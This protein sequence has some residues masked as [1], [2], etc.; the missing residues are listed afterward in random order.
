MTTPNDTVLTWANSNLQFEA[1]TKNL[2]DILIKAGKMSSMFGNR[3]KEAGSVYT[4]K[5]KVRWNP[6]IGYVEDG[7]AFP[8]AGEQTYV[9]AKVGMRYLAAKLPITDGVMFGID[10]SGATV[11]DEAT[12]ELQ[13][14]TESAAKLQNWMCF[15]DGTGKVATVK[16]GS[17]TTTLIV[18]DSRMMWEGG[19]YDIYDGSTYV[20]TVT[21]SS[22]SQTP[23]SNGW[24]TITL[25]AAPTNSMVSGYSVVW[26]GSYNRAPSGLRKLIDNTA[27]TF[28]NVN[29]STYSN[30]SSLVLAPYSSTN[31]G[32]LT[33]QIL[34]KALSG[35]KLKTGADEDV[36]TLMVSSTP[37]LSVMEEM[38]ENAIRIDTSTTVNGVRI[39]TFQSALGT[40]GLMSDTDAPLNSLYI[41]DTSDLG[42]REFRPFGPREGGDLYM[43]SNDQLKYI[44]TFVGMSQN[45]IQKRTTSAR[46][47]NI[48]IDLAV[49]T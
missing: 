40:L 22:K 7:A 36:T 15:G 32:S 5:V 43:R 35:V 1:W 45:F 37:M 9:T 3:I 28:Q 14:L 4:F 19:S 33:P 12:Y 16:T 39:Q 2:P 41:V 26:G 31:P 44:S 24:A 29:V 49:Q 34:R 38:Y 30:Y 46:I 18:D 47:D 6:G 11:V 10:G 23:T 25:S 17:A 13:G 48:A 42:V 21:V 27:T 20:E 8:N